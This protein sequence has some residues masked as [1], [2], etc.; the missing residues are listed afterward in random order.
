VAMIDAVS[1]LVA[2]ASVVALKV[3]E[4]LPTREETH[5]RAEITAGLRH[6]WSDV[7]LRQTLISVGIALLVA[8]FLES[9]IF[10]AVQAFHHPP[11]FVGVVVSVQGVGAVIGGLSSARIIR[12]I[13][14]VRAIVLALGV[15][16]A[17]L[18]V[19]A[20]APTLPV[21]FVGIVLFG[22]ALPV[23]IVALNTLIQTRTPQRLMGRVSGAA[24]VV[25]GTPQSCSIALGA[26]LVT[27]ISYRGIFW[28]CAAVIAFSAGYLVVTLRTTGLDVHP[29]DGP[30]REVDDANGSNAALGAPLVG[31]WSDPLAG[32]FGGEPTDR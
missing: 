21:F 5:W 30:V 13:G 14:E 15:I 28:I 27:L 6:I 11:S 1:F 26:L 17:G 22:F 10:A 18:A 23:F 20:A 12:A 3:R 29:I 7:I 31:P 8:G 2:A 19:D 25:V 4:N 32:P 16:T 9:A 24:D